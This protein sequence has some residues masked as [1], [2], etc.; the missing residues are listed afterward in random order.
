M[1]LVLLVGAGIVALL[2][3]A[4]VVALLVG[5]RLPLEHTATVS[6]DIAW[7]VRR[8]AEV[9]RNVVD[10]PR[11]RT[12]VA[13]IEILEQSDRVTRYVEHGSNGAIPF[14]FRE[15]RNSAEFRSTI[16]TDQLPFGGEWTITLDPLDASHTRITIREDGVVRSALFRFVSR[17]IMGHT[18]TIET[19]LEDLARFVS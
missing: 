14:V 2:V 7:P 13:R 11:W 5:S 10:Q 3:I 9:V 17:Y 18:R 8:V 6:R 16:D 19:Y 15:V 4:A 12:G 1:K